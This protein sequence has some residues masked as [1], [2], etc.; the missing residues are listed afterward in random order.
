MTSAL[1][2]NGSRVLTPHE[3]YALRSVISKPSLLALFNLLLYSGMRLSEVRQLV[4]NPGLFDE[5]RKTILIVSGK[6]KAT[7]RDRNILLNEKG[8]QA[9]REF[10]KNP[11]YPQS[12]FAW[13]KNLIRWCRAAHLEELQIVEHE[14]NR[15]GVTV[16]S[17]RKTW[18]SW[19][20]T[21]HEDKA[22][23]I[24]L[25]QGHKEST[26]IGHYLNLLFTDEEYN[27][28]CE[29]VSDWGM[30]NGRT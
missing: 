6:A 28:I 25:S 10:L 30:R 3:V 17:T 18:E 9:V 16:R 27:Q 1:V 24:A 13:Q 21:C 29:E 11:V 8:L 2:S 19:L 12:P 15:Y 4:E 14:S 5:E 7:Q 20:M 22:V 23:R 26:Q